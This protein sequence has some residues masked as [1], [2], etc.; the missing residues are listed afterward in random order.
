MISSEICIAE[1]Y[2]AQA[3][4]IA[5]MMTSGMPSNDTSIGVEK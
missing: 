4:R 1:V 5:V 2:G 3:A